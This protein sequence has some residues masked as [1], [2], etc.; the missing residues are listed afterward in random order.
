MTLGEFSVELEARLENVSDEKVTKVIKLT[1]QKIQSDCVASM[2]NTPRDTSK[3]Y[4]TNNESKAHHPSF[5]G[6]P[7]ASDTGTLT[8]SIHY[9]IGDCEGNIG[10][11][12][13]YGLWLETGTTRGLK[14]RPWLFPAVKNNM[15]FL[16]ENLIKLMKGNKPDESGGDSE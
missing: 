12:L 3:S 6:N 7:P 13:D 14:P 11:N 8:G 4:F 5:P 10:T 15:E 16:K 9:S 1:C 2:N